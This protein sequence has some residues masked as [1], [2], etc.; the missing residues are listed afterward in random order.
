MKKVIELIRKELPEYQILVSDFNS[1]LE[2]EVYKDKNIINVSRFDIRRTASLIKRSDFFFG[3]DSG[4]MHLAGAVGTKSLV[5]FGSIPPEVRINHYP[6][7]KSIRDDSL[8][9]IGCW[10]RECPYNTKCMKNIKPEVVLK[11]IR[12]LL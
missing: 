3:P 4:L 10:Y 7:H 8:K 6:T 12:R 1:V 5:A 11:K 9:C 2:N